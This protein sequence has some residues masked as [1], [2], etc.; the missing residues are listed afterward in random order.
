M[1]VNKINYKE[2]IEKL[3]PFII[4][5]P[6][7][8]SINHGLY[9]D[10]LIDTSGHR[11]IFLKPFPLSFYLLIPL[12][13][14]YYSFKKINII[15]SIFILTLFFIFFL[16]ITYFGYTNNKISYFLQIIYPTAGIIIGLNQ[17]Q[18]NNL[19]YVF[20]IIFFIII[21]NLL[22]TFSTGYILLRSNLIVFTI[23]QNL[24]YVSSMLVSLSFVVLLTNEKFFSKKNELI[25]TSV[26]TFYA[27]CSF[28]F[29]NLIICLF[30]LIIYF[31]KNYKSITICFL[32]ISF[33]MGCI[34]FSSKVKLSDQDQKYQYNRNFKT[35]QLNQLMSGELPNN[36]K[37]RL[38]IYKEFFRKEFE[39]KEFLI[40]KR[41]LSFLIENKSTH[42]IFLDYLLINGIFLP[43]VFFVVFLYLQISNLKFK[44]NKFFYSILFFS[45]A[46]LIE[47]IFKVSM[48]QPYTGLIIFY[49]IGVFL[50]EFQN[51]QKDI[52]DLSL[53]SK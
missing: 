30:G 9:N 12:F 42:N 10:D 19:K 39:L 14:Y 51:Y 40:G 3:T 17:K 36:I 4:I 22:I 13:F 21:L 6:I 11:N 48:R 1:L 46:I 38:E 16:N 20:I 28:N 49:L 2:L 44:K 41:N 26:I 31:Y 27:I 53:S 37:V 18:L 29:S 43:I 5:L 33:T 15:Y 47:N 52:K 8:F 32:I 7:F 50:K 25:F 24:Q 23:Y 35:K 45:F 34:F